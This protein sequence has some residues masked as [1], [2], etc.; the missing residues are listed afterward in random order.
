MTI[1][2]S[3]PVTDDG[4]TVTEVRTEDDELIGHI[5]KRVPGIDGSV[6]YDFVHVTHGMSSSLS[7]SRYRD[8][9]ASVRQRY[10]QQDGGSDA[11][12]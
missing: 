4:L 12:D 7:E 8:I 1:R 10:G 2:F 11:T 6:E 9:K 5:Y 3:R